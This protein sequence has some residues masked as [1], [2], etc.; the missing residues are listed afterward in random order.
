M[1]TIQNGKMEAV[2]KMGVGR[3]PVS[4]VLIMKIEENSTLLWKGL[5]L[6]ERK[7]ARVCSPVFYKEQPFFCV[8]SWDVK[9]GLWSCSLLL[10]DCDQSCSL[11]P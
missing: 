6:L 2:V 11:T 1:N 8:N 4:L 5:K 10:R 9:L 7:W 3:R